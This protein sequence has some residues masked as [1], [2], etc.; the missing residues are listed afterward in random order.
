MLRARSERLCIHPISVEKVET[1]Q[2]PK[3]AGS[4]RQES[5]PC[6]RFWQR[7][8]TVAKNINSDC[9]AFCGFNYRIHQG[10]GSR[11]L[12]NRDWERKIKDLGSNFIFL[13]IFLL[14]VDFPPPPVVYLGR[15]H[16]TFV[17]GGTKVGENWTFWREV[18]QKIISRE[19]NNQQ[20]QRVAGSTEIVTFRE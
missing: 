6:V 11:S 18:R 12:G 9:W 17:S 19:D 3:E 7:W 5:N 15:P 16:G 10:S 1:K 14:R 4:T 20:Q 8:P 2:R 13:N